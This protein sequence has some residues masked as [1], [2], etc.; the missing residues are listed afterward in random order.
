MPVTINGTSGVVTATTFSGS[1]LTGIDTGKILQVLQ[2]TKV[3]TQSI[4][5]T[6]F[7]DIAGLNQSITTT[8]SNKVLVTFSVSVATTNYGMVKLL[9]GSTDIFKGDATNNIINCTVAAITQ[10]SYEVETYSHSYLDTP[11]AG[12]HTYKLQFG[13]PHSSA[14]YGYVNQSANHAN[15]QY[16]PQPVS[17]ITLYEVAAWP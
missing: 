6:S 5:G 2:T 16:V 11:G 1:S 3:N 8:G 15:Q 7:V 9:R 4:Q 12:T 14:Y 13:L 10:N 17:S